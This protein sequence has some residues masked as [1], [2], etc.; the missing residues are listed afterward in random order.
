MKLQIM[1][2]CQK[3]E[4]SISVPLKVLRSEDLMTTGAKSFLVKLVDS[5]DLVA[6][7]RTTLFSDS[8]G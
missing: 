7:L 3:G 6:G 1:S 5:D 2:L 8:F 4:V